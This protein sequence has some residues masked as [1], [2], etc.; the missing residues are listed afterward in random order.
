LVDDFKL[1]GDARSTGDAS[2]TNGDPDALGVRDVN[3]LHV[4]VYDALNDEAN[5][6]DFCF[7]IVF[8]HSH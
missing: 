6:D 7:I 2:L 5:D 4:N 1:A 3:E 8:Q